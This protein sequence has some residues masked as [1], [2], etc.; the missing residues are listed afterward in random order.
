ML[1]TCTGS[2]GIP[3]L[4]PAALEAVKQWEYCPTLVNGAPVEVATETSV[5]FTLQ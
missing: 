4:A 5:I 3:L 1:L 2:A